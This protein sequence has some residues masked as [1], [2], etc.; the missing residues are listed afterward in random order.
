M[1]HFEFRR[2]HLVRIYQ[3]TCDF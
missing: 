3:W 2:P 1:E